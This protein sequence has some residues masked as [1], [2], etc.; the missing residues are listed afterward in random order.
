MTP[1]TL[2]LVMCATLLVGTLV[3]VIRDKPTGGS[4]SRITTPL[5]ISFA[6]VLVGVVALCIM[7]WRRAHPRDETPRGSQHVVAVRALDDGGAI[8]EGNSPSSPWLA[9]YDGKRIRWK[10]A[11]PF[12]DAWNLAVGGD[13]VFMVSETRPKRMMLVDIETGADRWSKEIQAESVLDVVAGASSVFLDA[14]SRWLEVSTTTGENTRVIEK[15]SADVNL[16][17]GAVESVEQTDAHW[18]GTCS[19]TLNGKSFE[20]G[21]DPQAARAPGRMRIAD[22]DGQRIVPMDFVPNTCGTFQDSL[23]LF[24]TSSSEGPLRMLRLNSAGEIT[25]DVV[26]VEGPKASLFVGDHRV[27]PLSGQLP[28]FVPVQT[29]RARSVDAYEYKNLVIDLE[30]SVITPGAAAIDDSDPLANQRGDLDPPWM[31]HRTSWLRAVRHE[32]EVFDGASGRLG[33]SFALS[34]QPFRTSRFDLRQ[35]AGGKLWLSDPS[36]DD[37]A[38]VRLDLASMTPEILIGPV[39]VSTR[40]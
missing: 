31:L 12:I 21:F 28:R 18:Y 19:C 7:L 13:Y 32:V 35:A 15:K 14:G 38:L 30:T 17:N 33:G 34:F 2:V 29:M 39:Q 36:A 5:K 9:R 25:R 8:V 22:N 20:F 16:V 23:V 37:I 27:Q 26:V 1:M 11:V 10:R 4:R 3:S 6:L 40:K 24:M